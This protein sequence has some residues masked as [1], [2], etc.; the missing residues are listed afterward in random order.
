MD[1]VYRGKLQVKYD[2]DAPVR[3]DQITTRIHSGSLGT[4]G[5]P[6]TDTE[7]RV[8][9]H[10]GKVIEGLFAAGNAMAGVTG[11]AKGGE[12]N[13]NNGNKLMRLRVGFQALTVLLIVVYVVLSRS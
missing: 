2:F 1:G 3:I 12:F 6:R 4:K 13:K 9:D 8:L 11:M 10:Q 7:G 5:G